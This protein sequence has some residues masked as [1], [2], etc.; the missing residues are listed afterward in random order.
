M[1]NGLS[2][3]GEVIKHDRKNSE[4]RCIICGKAVGASSNDEGRT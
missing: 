2:L 4:L 3:C 1:L